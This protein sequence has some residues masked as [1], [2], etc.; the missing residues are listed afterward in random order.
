MGAGE[1][2]GRLDDR[3]PPD[4]EDESLAVNP[5][6]AV[7]PLFVVLIGNIMLTRVIQGRDSSVLGLVPAAPLAATKIPVANWALIISL[8][9]AIFIAVIVGRRQF[10][11]KKNLTTALNAGAIGSLLAIMNTASEVG[12]GNVISSLPG[13]ESVKQALLGIDFGTPLVSEALVINVLAICGM[14]HKE[15]YPDCG[16]VSVTIPFVTTFLLVAIWTFFGFTS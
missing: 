9:L 16:M 13:F 10:A 12:Y 11:A 6:L 2:F 8:V 15:S 7:I 3:A 14:T 5:Y 1:G 4:T